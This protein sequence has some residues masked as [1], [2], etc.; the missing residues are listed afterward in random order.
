MADLS[1][2]KSKS[3]REKLSKSRRFQLMSEEEQAEQIERI[4]ALPAAQQKNFIKFFTEEN[5]FEEEK[6]KRPENEQQQLLAKFLEDLEALKTKFTKLALQD[7]EKL[8]KAK[9]D[10]DEKK[11]LEDI[12]NL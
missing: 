9:E 4:A 8:S 11:L 12:N 6:Y 7:K 10:K 3:L 1:I 5:A 2:V